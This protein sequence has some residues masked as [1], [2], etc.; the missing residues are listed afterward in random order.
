MNPF[1][2]R[3][4]YVSFAR[5]RAVVFWT[6]NPRPILPHLAELDRRGIGYYFQFTL[7]D[8]RG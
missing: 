8:L 1:N 4:Q 5:T 3:P 2:G 6:K 7:N